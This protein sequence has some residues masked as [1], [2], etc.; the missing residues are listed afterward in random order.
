MSNQ[1]KPTGLL[2]MLLLLTCV[3]VPAQQPP[4]APASTRVAIK[5]G[6]LL[7]VRTGKVATNVYIVIEKDRIVSLSRSAPAGVSV[8]D[9]SSQTV[10]PGLVDCHVHLLFNW[11]DQSSAAVLRMSSPQ[12]TL[13]GWR[14]LQT[15]LNEGFTTLRD[16]GEYDA[17]YG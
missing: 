4:P 12:G 13:W 6:R 7:D 3:G 5:A 11:K 16:A 1:R 15:Y 8:I 2:L 14:N 10:L 17:F 9:L